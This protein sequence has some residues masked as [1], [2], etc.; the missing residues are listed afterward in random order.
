[1]DDAEDAFQATFLALVRKGDSIG[2]GASVGGWLYTVAYRAAL[3]ARAQAALQVGQE[4]CLEDLPAPASSAEEVVW[5]DLRPVLDA[6]VNRL[7]RKYR[8]PF[9]L[10]CLEGKSNEE[11]ARQLGCPTGTLVTRLARARQR[12]RRRLTG[13]GL[14]LTAGS[15][16]PVFAPEA[17]AA[18]PALLTAGT[19]RALAGKAVS[20]RVAGLT[21]G[22]L[23]ALT[24]TGLKPAVALVLAVVLLGF[25]GTLTYRALAGPPGERQQPEAAMPPP[26]GPREEAKAPPA[27]KGAEIERLIRQLGSERFNER[28]AATTALEGI[29]EPAYEALR[30]A[31][32]DSDDVEIRRRAERII[33]LIEQRWEVRRFVGHTNAIAIVAFSPDGRRV[34]SSSEDRTVRLWD[35]ET[36][37]ELRRFV[38]HT[39]RVFSVAFS[40]DGRRALSGSQDG[41]ARLW[42]VETGKELRRFTEHTAG[43]VGVAFSPN[44]RLALSAG[45]DRTMRLWDPETGK[46]L[47]IFEGHTGEVWSAEFSADGRRALSSSEDKTN[48]LWDVETGKELR[49]FRGHTEPVD[50]AVV[51]PNGKQALSSCGD[52]TVRLWDLETGKELRR[53]THPDKLNS[54]AVS[55]DGRWALSGGKDG[56]VRLWDLATGKELRRF[57]GHTD[58]VYSVTFS[59]DGRWALSGS[60]DGTIRLWQLP[61]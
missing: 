61:K 11:A 33:R 56:V 22:A 43:V 19:V 55:P 16:L 53:F 45:K 58:L 32:D 34:L 24:L 41:T 23:R 52:K 8:E 60:Y 50:N 38:G 35:A 2:S 4:Q 30:Q 59:P 54:V 28:E 14:T 7:P 6:E 17:V 42:D 37:K 20:P 13:R 18:V 44:G 29:G 49:C 46:G 27:S 47:R 40:P 57:S 15:L 10:C 31:A 51:C 9:V 21:S 5:R 25:A 12:L 39:E 1:V 26:A 36:G 3:A 48:R